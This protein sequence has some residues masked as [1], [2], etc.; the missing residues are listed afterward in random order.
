MDLVLL[1]HHVVLLGMKAV[2]GAHTISE[3]FHK[4]LGHEGCENSFVYFYVWV[5]FLIV[6]VKKTGRNLI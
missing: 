3:F 2:K 1:G 6:R 4:I 5:I